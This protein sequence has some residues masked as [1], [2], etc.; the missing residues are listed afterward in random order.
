MD[1]RNGDDRSPLLPAGIA[2]GIGLGG[3][4]DGI[5]F[6]QLL[7][8]HNMLSAMYPPTTVVN[9]EF[10][11]LWDG[12]F[13]VFTWSMTV[14]GIVLLWRAGARPEVAWCGRTLF[15][16]SLIGWGAFNV[17]EGTIDHFIL[18]IHH[19]VERAGLSIYDWAFL[20]SGIVLIGIGFATI[21]SARRGCATEP[22]TPRAA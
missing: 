15:G 13:H 11:M 22:A 5:L 6:H 3:F 18:Q 19:V 8:I 4:V 20:A 2:L 1:H 10:N 16:A 17:I 7:Q 14:L 9:I 21:R 12:I